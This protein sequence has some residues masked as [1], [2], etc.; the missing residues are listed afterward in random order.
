MHGELTCARHAALGRCVLCGRPYVRPGP[1]GWRPF[2]AGELR[3]PTCCGLDPIETQLDARRR[4]PAIRADLAAV[5]VVLTTRVRVSL[6]DP[7]ELQAE[8]TPTGAGTILGL[9]DHLVQA[10]DAHVAVS[11]RVAAGLP[12]MW[13]GRTVA[14]EIG[15][16]WLVQQGG[17]AA[18]P[19]LAEGLCELFAHAWLK[20]QPGALAAEL[21]RQLQANPDRV[22]GGGFRMV[23]AAVL[24]VGIG[25]VLE[26]LALRGA[27]PG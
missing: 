5:G 21:R 1:P 4:L 13:F 19:E 2:T 9:T 15:H 14:H 11:I 20:R 26:G 23:H 10:G 12:A 3:C 25:T 27:L 24:R 17:P 7:A 6:V 16:A 18:A 8:L 22:Y